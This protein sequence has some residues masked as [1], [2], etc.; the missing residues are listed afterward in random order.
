MRSSPGDIA[1]PFPINS[2]ATSLP[3]KDDSTISSIQTEQSNIQ[4]APEEQFHSESSMLNLPRKDG[5]FSSSSQMDESRIASP[6]QELDHF[7]ITTPHV[8]DSTVPNFMHTLHYGNPTFNPSIPLGTP[9]THPDSGPLVINPLGPDNLHII[10]KFYP[11]P[12]VQKVPKP[13][14]I[15]D[16][17]VVPYPVHQKKIRYIPQPYPQPVSKPDVHLSYIHLENRGKI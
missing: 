8:D 13:I 12:V 17:K 1:E 7:H 15:M 4:N 6:R 5:L 10:K 3:N 9:I 14:P 11:L 16:T 2:F